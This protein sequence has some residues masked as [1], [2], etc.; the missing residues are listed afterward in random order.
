MLR[1]TEGILLSKTAVPQKCR[2][3]FDR[4]YFQKLVNKKKKRFKIIFN[5]VLIGLNLHFL[6]IIV[7]FLSLLKLLRGV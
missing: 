5:N 2:I 1:T 6:T 7:T 3:V 4:L